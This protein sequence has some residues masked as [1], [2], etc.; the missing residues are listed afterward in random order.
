MA[1]VNED[2]DNISK[3][4]ETMET[5]LK[6]DYDAVNLTAESK[7]DFT[8]VDKALNDAL[9]KA[10]TAQQTADKENAAAVAEVNTAYENL[11][12][13]YNEAETYNESI[14]D[15]DLKQQAET[16]SPGYRHQGST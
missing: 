2:F 14:V 4:L 6:A 3:A 9:A 16:G 13:L 7:L 5:Q 12:N 1:V 10:K 15:V 8:A 11:Q